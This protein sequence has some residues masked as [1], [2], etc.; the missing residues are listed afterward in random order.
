MTKR[1]LIETMAAAAEIPKAAAERAHAAYLEA[2]KASLVD[3]EGYLEHGIG[4][5]TVVERGA[6]MGTHP[7]TGERMEIPASKTVK[8]KVAKKLKDLINAKETESA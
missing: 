3:G 5:Y 1:E 7:R 6:R 8:F 4:N 2:L